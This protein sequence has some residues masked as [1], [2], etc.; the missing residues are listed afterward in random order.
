MKIREFLRMCLFGLIDG[1][2]RITDPK[3]TFKGLAYAIAPIL[4]M[5]GIVD[6][7]MEVL[8][9]EWLLSVGSILASLLLALKSGK[10]IFSKDK[11]PEN[12]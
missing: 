3:T 1:I 6:K 9:T 4:I 12:K 8:L 10:L 11:K 7:S 5:L 2:D